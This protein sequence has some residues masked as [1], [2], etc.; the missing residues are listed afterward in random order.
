[1]VHTMVRV[2]ENPLRLLKVVDG[3]G[4]G[5]GVVEDGEADSLEISRTR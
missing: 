4:V 1:M 2:Q 5:V 3:L